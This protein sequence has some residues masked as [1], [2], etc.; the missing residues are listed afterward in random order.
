MEALASFAQ[1]VISSRE[2]GIAWATALMRESIA[3]LSGSLPMSQAEGDRPEN[4]L[5]VWALLQYTLILFVL[6]WGLRLGVVQPLLGTLT[7]A[8]HGKPTSSVKLEK[9]SQS[10]MEALNYGISFVVGVLVVLPQ[11]WCYPGSEWYAG[12]PADHRFTRL[13]HWYYLI[14]GA[15]Y[16]QGLI[17]VF[18]EH[19]RK[20]FLEMV[21]HHIVTMTL[22]VHSFFTNYIRVG[23]II[24]VVFDPADVPLHVAKV[25]RYFDR[26]TEAFKFVTDRFF[27][28]FAVIFTISRSGV[29]PYIVYESFLYWDRS[30]RGG[31][32]TALLASL[33]ILQLLN[34]Y[35]LYLIFKAVWAI[36]TVGAAPEDTRSDDE[37]DEPTD[38]KPIARTRKA[39]A[40]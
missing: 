29:F 38:E 31:E 40:T 34:W 4:S 9:M 26:D 25:L 1:E 17:S 8:W 35:W 24:M 28:L 23:A 19:R 15:R 2:D 32:E 33:G 3:T 37:G 14:Y 11:D 20:D 12:S 27:E 10:V 36:V 6:N 30:G 13:L 21:I 16:C 22:V 5:V 7:N 18:L 39:K